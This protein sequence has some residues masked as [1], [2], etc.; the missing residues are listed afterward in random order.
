MKVL[1]CLRR[2]IQSPQEIHVRCVEIER[3]KLSRTNVGSN[4]VK[5][6]FRSNVGVPWTRPTNSRSNPRNPHF[7]DRAH[8]KLE[9][10]LETWTRDQR[11]VWEQ[12]QG[13]NAGPLQLPTTPVPTSITGLGTNVGTGFVG[14]CRGSYQL[15]GQPSCCRSTGRSPN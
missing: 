15:R 14:N 1:L 5:L 11:K 8:R 10:L 3:Q 6:Y 4:P 7:A 13:T 9:S 2:S 12:M